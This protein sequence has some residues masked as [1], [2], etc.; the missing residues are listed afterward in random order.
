[1]NLN[2]FLIEVD[3][4]KYKFKLMQLYQNNYQS[5]YKEFM[6]FQIIKLLY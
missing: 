2:S 6:N 1:M 3:N 4:L 5:F